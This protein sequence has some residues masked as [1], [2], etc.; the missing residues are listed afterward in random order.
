MYK[1][2]RMSNFIGRNKEVDTF[3]SWL[4]NTNAPW[5]LYIHDAAEEIDKKGGVGKTWLLR[6]CAEIVRQQYPDTTIVMA[7]FFNIGDRDRIFLAEKILSG[8]SSLYPGWQPDA[9]LEAASQIRKYDILPSPQSEEASESSIRESATIALASDLQRL[10]L[11]LTEQSKTL[12]VFLDTYEVIEDNPVVAVLRRTQTFPDNYQFQSMRVVIAGRNQLD[13]QH[14]NWQGREQEVQVMALAPFDLEEMREY[15]EA[16][17]IY[18]IPPHSDTFRALYQRTE[19]R[20]III[21]LAI[22]VLNNR[23]LT[24]N[25]MLSVS[26]TEFEQYLVPQINKLENPLN[27]VILF[28]AHVYHR[29][30]ITLLEWIL[31]SV[32]LN[33]PVRPIRRDELAEFL[34]QLSFVRRPDVGD[35]F[36]LHDEMRRLVTRYCWV[37]LDPD[38]RFRKDISRSI[39]AYYEDKL[40]VTTNEQ[41][42]QGHIIENLYHHLYVDLNEGLEYYHKQFFQ[43][44]EFLKTASARLLLQETQNFLPFMSLAQRNEFQLTEV[45]LY[46]TEDNPAAALEVLQQISQNADPQWYEEN[47][48]II[49]LEEGRNYVKQSKLAQAADSYM[50]SL[51][52]ELGRGDKLQCAKLFNNLGFTCRRRGQFTAALEYHEQS[53][54]LYKDLG[55]QSDYA[56]VLG[57]ISNVYRLQGKIEEALRR[58]KIAWHIRKELAKEGKIP[59]TLVGMS[60]QALGIIYLDSGDIMEAELHFKMAHDIFLRTNYKVGIATIYNHFGQFQI[61]KGELA[62]ALEWVKKSEEAS[63]EIDTEQYIVSFNKQGRIKAL[64]HEWKEAL[65]LFEL[66]ISIARSVPAY[67]QLTESLIDL[68]KAFLSLEQPELVFQYLNDAEEIA[69]REHYQLLLGVIEQ[70]RAEYFYLNKDYDTAF[71]HFTLYCHHMAQYNTTELSIAVRRSTDALMGAPK[72]IKP[73]VTRKMVDYWNTHQLAKD[74][75]ELI[76]AIE[77]IDN[78]MVL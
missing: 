29:F 26:R 24:I 9:F 5:I 13:W 30:N 72:D 19:G 64:Q 14:P 56:H 2:Q 22:D 15:I 20:P 38:R 71:N 48:S 3:I 41:E 76:N 45:R 35:D 52:I 70:I 60:E 33:E 42:R 6:R 77:E 61:N 23:I 28:M 17:S 59:E 37:T 11:S 53:I 8:L 7:D 32:S 74:H 44:L 62:E 46:R 43:A 50:R 34:P 31:Q 68:A 36:V 65:P 1:Q 10:D 69:T 47:K 21:G 58:C 75:P 25:D 67:Y 54:A 12:L 40:A 27:W 18:D 39:I 51:E 57:N 49:F 16:E 73:I 55:R 66:A 4:N 63:K 78:L